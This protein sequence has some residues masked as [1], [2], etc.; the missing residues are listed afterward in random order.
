LARL[1]EIAAELKEEAAPAVSSS[2]EIIA[3][4]EK[5]WPRTWPLLAVELVARFGVN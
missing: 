2:E 4:I 3:D 5:T 1:I